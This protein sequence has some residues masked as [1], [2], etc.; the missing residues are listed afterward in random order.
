MSTK[1]R[2]LLAD[3]AMS[4][5]GCRDLERGTWWSGWKK[6]H[7]PATFLRRGFRFYG[8]DK[9]TRSLFGLIEITKG[10]SFTY[11]TLTEFGRKAKQVADHTPNRDDPHWNKLPLPARGQFCTGYA[12]RWRRIG[13]VDIPWRGRFP[14]LGWA[15]LPSDQTS[16]SIDADQSFVEGDR[17]YREH[18]KIE[19][20]SRLRAQARDFWRDKLSGL[21]CLACGFSFEKRYGAWGAEFV[22]MHHI[23]PLASIRKAQEKNVKALVPLCANCHR[24]VHLRPKDLLPMKAL[25]RMLAANSRIHRDAR[26][27]SARA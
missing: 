14:Q 4:M 2:E 19:R 5:K 23:V 12:I 10:S 20:S 21:R 27:S 8:Y 18:L 22:E 25:K 6:Q 9:E 16:P 3:V 7:W 1:S 24:M 17:K 15:R 11:R 13:K 26:K